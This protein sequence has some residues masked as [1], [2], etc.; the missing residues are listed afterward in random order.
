[1]PTGIAQQGRHP[2]IAIATILPSQGDDVS[3][4]CGF[5]ICPTRHLALCRSMLPE[6]MADPPL[7]HRHHAPNM[8]D[9]APAARGAQKFPRA[10]S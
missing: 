5:V 9:T 1:M 6:H 4:E 10:A 3:S 2:A 8:I 7:G